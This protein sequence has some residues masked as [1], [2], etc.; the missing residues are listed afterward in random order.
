M[1]IPTLQE[2]KYIATI[3]SKL[4]KMNPSVEVI[5]VDGRS[6]DGTVEVARC[7]T[8]KVYQIS[9]RGIAKARNYGAKQANGDILI[10][11]DADV[12]PPPDFIE[13][14]LKTFSDNTVVGATCAIMPSRPRLIETIFF[15]LYNLVIR[16]CTHI[17]PHSRG[18][19]FAVRKKTFL[20]VG[21]FNEDM[22]CLEDHD[23]AYRLSRHGR[24]VFIRG[25]TVYESLRRFR[26]LGFLRVLGTWVIDY[27]A[28]IL[29]GKPV[30]G[31]W[32]PVR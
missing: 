4:I 32:K 20:Q 18:E 22:P 26:K 24:F 8:D 28:Y 30:S 15:Y 9:E 27:I 21:G 29:R 3:L 25:L 10:F 13:K 12:D 6:E 2:E 17:R 14:V 1:V 7:F 23:L 16:F 31:V 11:L 19:F 5:V